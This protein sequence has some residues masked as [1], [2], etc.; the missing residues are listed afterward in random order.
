MTGP[1]VF[2]A[3]VDLGAGSGRVF[4]GALGGR[5]GVHEVHRF[6]YAPAA[7]RGICRWD[8]AAL[9]AGLR[10]GAAR[11]AEAARRQGGVLDS[12]GVDAWG[13]DYGLIDADGRLLEDPICYRDEPHGD[14]PG[15]V[16]ARVRAIVCSTP[17][18]FSG[19]DQHALPARGPRR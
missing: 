8:A 12:I 13:V 17:P 16:L 14:V 11:A 19:S 18:G 15:K 4:V 6:T 7:A 9:F 5:A 10:D 3:A 2:R 1:A